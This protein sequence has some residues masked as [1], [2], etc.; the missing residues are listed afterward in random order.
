MALAA[1]PDSPP[2]AAEILIV[3]VSDEGELTAILEAHHDAA[4]SRKHVD[5][6]IAAGP[7]QARQDSRES[8]NEASEAQH[9]AQEAQQ[10]ANDARNEAREAQQ[11]ANEAEQEGGSSG[12]DPHTGTPEQKGGGRSGS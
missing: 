1:G 3:A 2:P 8:M 7:H 6:R 9:D 11:D 10:D 4:E 12:K 5:E